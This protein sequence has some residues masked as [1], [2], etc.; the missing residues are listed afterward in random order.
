MQT[1]THTHT[2][3]QDHNKINED[4]ICMRHIFTSLLLFLARSQRTVLLFFF[5]LDQRM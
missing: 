3:I 4:V 5:R 2:H 1:H